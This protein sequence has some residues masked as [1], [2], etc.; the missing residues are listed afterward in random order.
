[1]LEASSKADH[2]LLLPWQHL[3]SIHGRWALQNCHYRSWLESP[4]AM[5]HVCLSFIVY[6]FGLNLSLFV[7]VVQYRHSTLC[8]WRGSADKW[9]KGFSEN[10]CYGSLNYFYCL[11]FH[12]CWE[13][14]LFQD[15]L[16]AQAYENCEA[17][18]LLNVCVVWCSNWG[19]E[20]VVP[21]VFWFCAVII[22]TLKPFSQTHTKW[23]W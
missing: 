16:S 20:L 13:V 9:W 22:F 18:L 5:A 23:N 17:C 7:M 6:F 2:R 21:H 14:Q 3:I 8:W 4:P 15:N 12:D 1:M 19:A 10:R 11:I